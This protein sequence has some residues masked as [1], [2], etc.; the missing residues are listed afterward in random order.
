[1]L[2]VFS[3]YASIGVLN[4][5]IHWGVFAMCVYGIHTSQTLANFAGFIV[6]VSFSF[7]ANARFT[8]KS[9]TTAIRYILYVGFMGAL[10]VAVGW[11][12][13]KSELP[14]L[15]TLAIFSGISLICGFI[16]SK[17][18]VFKDTK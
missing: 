8:F 1:M 14:P 18:I 13:D 4:T 16:Y 2:T 9:S 15:L 6:A 5:L 11:V 10:S 3:K 7:Y 17:F 12:A